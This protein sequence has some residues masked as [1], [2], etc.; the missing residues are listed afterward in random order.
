MILKSTEVKPYLLK[1]S[2]VIESWNISLEENWFYSSKSHWNFPRINVNKMWSSAFFFCKINNKCHLCFTVLKQAFQLLS[3]TVF[4]I[5]PK[6]WIQYFFLSA[7]LLLSWQPSSPKTAES[8]NSP[9]ST[10]FSYVPVQSRNCIGTV[11]PSV[12]FFSSWCFCVF[13]LKKSCHKYGEEQAGGDCQDLLVCS[14]KWN[15]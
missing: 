7:A 9:C 10:K 15:K 2:V 8:Q 12:L 5:F 11:F 13:G 4:S 1:S 14:A 6:L 3:S